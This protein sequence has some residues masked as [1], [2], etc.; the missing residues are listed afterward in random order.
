MCT[1]GVAL[2]GLQYHA[3]LQQGERLLI[4][5]ATGGVGIHAIQLAKKMFGATVVTITSSQDK[6]SILHQY[7]ADEVIVCQTKEELEQFHRRIRPVDVVLECVGTPTLGAS[8][9]SLRL[10]GRLVIVGNVSA[11]KMMFNPG[12]LILKELKLF[13]SNGAS[14]KELEQVLEMTAQGRLKP[15]VHS[16]MPLEMIHQAHRLLTERGVVGRI[17]LVPSHNRAFKL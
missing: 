16:V 7:G 11:T 2:R 15:V 14:R 17:V 8:I 3:D 9:R 1:A 12:L 10:G 6:V 5:G 13:G 4:T